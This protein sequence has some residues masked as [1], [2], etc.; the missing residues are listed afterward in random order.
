MFR[1]AISKFSQLAVANISSRQLSSL[2]KP[3]SAA[4][5]FRRFQ[6]PSITSSMKMSVQA[7]GDQELHGF[8]T[9]EIA[10]EKKQAKSS[11]L[12]TT[13]EGFEIKGEKADVTLS[14]KHQDEVIEIHLNVNHTVDGENYDDAQQQQ[15]QQEQNSEMRSKPNF[16]IDIKKGNTVLSFSCSYVQD[17]AAAQTEEDYS[18]AFY[19]DEVTIYE[20]EWNDTVYSVA[21]DILDGYL[22]DLFMNMLE[23]RGISNEFVENLSDFCTDYEHHQYIGLLTKL[24]N[25]VGQK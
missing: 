3:S 20:G 15:N 5:V 4:S 22:Y 14:K 8:L 16:E 12:P 17:A 1:A 6:V 9:D 7:K 25:F 11:G 18:D 13:L 23:E 10:S 21:G 19:I 2:A 24:Q